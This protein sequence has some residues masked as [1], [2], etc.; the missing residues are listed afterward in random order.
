MALWGSTGVE[1]YG[2]IP[3]SLANTLREMPQKTRSSKSLVLMT[4]EQNRWKT[5][6]VNLDQLTGRFRGHFLGHLR[7]TFRGESLKG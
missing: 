6:Q 4:E 1:G 3:Q 2:C 7:G 5:G